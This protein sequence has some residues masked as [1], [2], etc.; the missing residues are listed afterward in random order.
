MNKI[1]KVVFF[2]SIISI[3]G[4]LLSGCTTSE[5]KVSEYNKQISEV[6]VLIES[7]EYNLALEK[8][9]KTSELIPS[10]IDA[11]QR[12]VDIFITKNR[13]EDATKIL[14]ESATKLEDSDRGSLYVDIGNAY[15]LLKDFDK[16]LYNY[17]IGKGFDSSNTVAS[18][19]IAKVYIQKGNIEGAKKLLDS[20]YEGDEY[21]ESQLLLS[22]LYSLN[23]VESAVE[24]I[25]DVE[26]G[27]DWRGKY[28]DWGK[29]LEGLTDDELFNSAKLGKVYMD[30]GYPYLSIAI[31]EPN[32]DKMLEYMDGIYILGKAYYEQGE[33]QKSIDLLEDGVFVSN[34]NQYVYWVLARDYYML[35]D[36]ETSFS[37]YETALSYGGDYAEQDLYMEY[38]DFLFE[39]NQTEKALEVMRRAERIFDRDW[40]KLYYMELYTLR[41]DFEKFE[42][43][44]E[45][46]DYSKLEDELKSD[47]LYVKGDYFIQNNQL[48]DAKRT[49]DLFWELDPY[50][51]RYNLLVAQ[52]SFQEGNLDDARIYSKKAIEYDTQREVTEQALK[53]LAQID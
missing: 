44:M 34:L 38:L 9:S 17:Q 10:R 50:D 36:L 22:Y 20:K 8:L 18:L 48:D 32:K 23:S 39:E 41:K 27:D 1:I 16:A 43:H 6:D 15:Y 21:I 40:V 4:F 2:L 3:S 7:M 45:S 33:Y 13:L 26:P 52:L 12:I 14:D 47:Y 19:G 11:Y 30:E 46:V 29:L 53:L 24:A 49:L 25:K 51:S 31:L 35:D 37:Y 5:E 28:T 42:Y